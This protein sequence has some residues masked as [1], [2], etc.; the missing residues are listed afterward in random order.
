[1]NEFIFYY[2]WKVHWIGISWKIFDV[3]IIHLE[4]PR[5]LNSSSVTYQLSSDQNI[6]PTLVGWDI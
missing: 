2:E 6:L 3:A 4:K 1:M 5:A